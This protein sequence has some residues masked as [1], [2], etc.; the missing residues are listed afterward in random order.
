MLSLQALVELRQY[1][2][3]SLL[4]YVHLWSLFLSGIASFRLVRRCCTALRTASPEQKTA[5]NMTA[6]LKPNSIKQ[7]KGNCLV[8]KSA[9]LGACKTDYSSSSSIILTNLSNTCWLTSSSS[10]LT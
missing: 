3:I 10:Q 4:K 6:F 5:S 9:L 1:N 7:L 2:T 8:K